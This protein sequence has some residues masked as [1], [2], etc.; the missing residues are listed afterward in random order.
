RE[1]TAF[2]KAF[3]QDE[4]VALPN[5]PVQYADFA[6]WQRQR[7]TD[8]V[9]ESQLSYWKHQL[10]GALPVLELPADKQRSRVQTYEGERQAFDLS[11]ALI[12]D[13]KAFSQREGVTVFMTLL[14][15]FKT[16]LHR[17]TSEHDIVVGSPIAGRNRAETENL[18]GFFVNTLVLRT[19]FSG[20]PTFRAVLQRVRETALGAYSNQDVA[21]E[22]LLEVLQP[23]RDMSHT[24]LFQVFF[25]MLNFEENTIELP[26]LTTRVLPP[27]E[28]M[29]KFD[30][31]LYVEEENQQLK[32]AFVYNQSRF[33]RERI[34]EMGEQLRQLLSAV[35]AQPEASIGS[36]SLVTPTATEF[37]PDAA[38][39][40]RPTWNGPVHVQFAEQA[41]RA[42]SRQAVVDRREAY[43]Y[44]ELDARSNQVAQ[45]LLA[46][47]VESQD[48]VAIYAERNASLVVA[49]LGIIK[50]GAAFM[51]LDP[52]YPPARLLY[53]LETIRPKGW[54]QI[55][56][57]GTPHATLQAYAE[58]FSF[59]LELSSK[60]N[61]DDSLDG[62]SA[63]E[64]GVAIGPQDM[65]YIAF[66][67]G[68]S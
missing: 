25:N 19:D 61:E 2:Y 8:Q 35:I 62:Y 6:L 59:S 47:G 55:G 43:T 4:P 58:S 64:T 65:A 54:I 16:L 28:V 60:A 42:P 37:L 17:L 3:V 7:A 31:T 27:S 52:A 10:E 66:T 13:V 14:A 5:L 24:P 12:S 26:E 67:S 44:E 9:L 57:A 33:S 56:E 30:L 20:N 11:A 15:V 29:A 34:V 22:Q 39:E 51:I 50:S 68:S 63:A 21:F 45:Y 53:C 48:V 18:I 41:R 23:E 32:F 40:F 38:C 46:H 1:L 49:L 36:V